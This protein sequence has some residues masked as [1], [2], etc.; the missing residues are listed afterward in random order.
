M[1]INR[2]ALES[3]FLDTNP[4]VSYWL[5]RQTGQVLSADDW[6]R[7]QARKLGGP[8]E[9]DDPHV[10]LA[11][12]LLWENAEVGSEEPSEEE[13]AKV[14]VIMEP[15]V[16]IPWHSYPDEDRLRRDV[17]DWLESEGL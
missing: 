8:D 3:A 11:W 6:S 2:I 15:L 14:R 10:R 9:T 17:D 1:T 7:E 16:S 12:C 5:D 4:D 13:R